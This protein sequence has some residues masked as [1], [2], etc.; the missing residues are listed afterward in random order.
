MNDNLNLNSNEK[1][2]FFFKFSDFVWIIELLFALAAFALILR[3]T[4]EKRALLHAAP[5]ALLLIAA[6]AAI[7]AAAKFVGKRSA[8]MAPALLLVFAVLSQVLTVVSVDSQPVS[9]FGLMYSSA[10]SALNGDFSWLETQY[11][12]NW[13]YQIPFV[14]YEAL[15]LSVCNSLRALQIMNIFFAVGC[16]WL[17]YMISSLYLGQDKAVLTGFVYALC[18]AAFIL[19][20]VLTN[21]HISL[22]FML[23]GLYVY[24]RYLD[25]GKKSRYVSAAAAGAFLAVGNLMRAEAVVIILSIIFCVM[26]YRCCRREFKAILPVALLTLVYFA[27][28]YAVGKIFALCGIAPYGIGNN[29]PQWKFVVGLDFMIGGT[30][31]GRNSFIL[32]ITDN[33]QRWQE[34]INAIKQSYAEGMSIPALI[35]NKVEAFWNSAEPLYFVF[36]GSSG[37]V[38]GIDVETFSKSFYLYERAYR[39]CLYLLSAAGVVKMLVCRKREFC[40]A[41]RLMTTIVCVFFVVYLLIEV[42]PRYRYVVNPFVVLM[43]S[44]LLLKPKARAP[45]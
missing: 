3:T 35:L 44:T 45:G 21:Q 6:L 16:I 7:F 1:P 19:T 17:V 18:P 42:Q 43:A 39:L 5:F 24:L 26:I 31:T 10:L 12:R 2:S 30:Y 20:P 37:E 34:T 40:F 15:V 13:A 23:L 41:L 27:L 33:A 22:F 8:I 36:T 4:P 38:M 14:M 9:D 29:A 32:S 11:Y 25:A 28:Q